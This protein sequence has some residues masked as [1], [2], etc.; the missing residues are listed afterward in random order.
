MF[1]P[2]EPVGGW[3][4]ELLESFEQPLSAQVELD[5]LE[6]QQKQAEEGGHLEQPRDATWKSGGIECRNV[7]GAVSFGFQILLTITEILSLSCL[8]HNSISLPTSEKEKQE[9]KL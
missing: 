2:K 5:C 4:W 8:N 1:V 3:T 7:Q 9:G 6:Q